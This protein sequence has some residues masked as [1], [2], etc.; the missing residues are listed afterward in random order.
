MNFY[1]FTF[2]VYLMTTKDAVLEALEKEKGNYLSGQF[3]AECCGVSRNAIWKNI[4]ELRKD[5]YQIQSV[6]NK[7][8]MLEM[9][10]NIISKAGICMY[11]E[12]MNNESFKAYDYSRLNVFDQI[13]STNIEA[14]R[15]ILMGNREH[16]N[17]IVAKSQTSGRGHGGS[18]FSS[19]D[20]G[21]YLSII[22]NPDEIDKNSDNITF[23]IKEIVSQIIEEYYNVSLEDGKYSSLYIGSQKV[24]GILTEGI[25]D[26]ETGKFSNYIVGVGIRTA[27]LEKISGLR[28]EKNMVIADLI[29]KI[30]LI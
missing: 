2:E 8:Y 13:D 28:P 6:N 20:G 1:K 19:P 16:G 18:D 10:N 27:E 26:L 15:N 23:S 9:D 25:V 17:V 14:K 12:N 22:L 3:L 11:L 5:G 30:Y 29:R 4:N 24:C 21:V 7:G